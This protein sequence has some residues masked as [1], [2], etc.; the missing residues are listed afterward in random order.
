MIIGKRELSLMS[1]TTALINCAGDHL[2]DNK[3]V[4]EAVK[5]GKLWGYGLDEVWQYP[6]LPL[7]GLNI[8]VSP[9]VGSDSDNGKIAIQMLSA[10]SVV[11]FLDGKKLSFLVNPQK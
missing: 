6:D 11:E 3:A 10:Q 9:H 5:N 4:Y 7:E 2:V 1:S 8:E